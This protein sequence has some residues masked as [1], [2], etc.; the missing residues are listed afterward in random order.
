[1]PRSIE[2]TVTREIVARHKDFIA[3]LQI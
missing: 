2:I 1:V 3:G